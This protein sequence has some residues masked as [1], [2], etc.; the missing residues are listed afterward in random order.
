[1]KHPFHSP[2]LIEALLLLASAPLTQAQTFKVIH[3]FTGGVDGSLPYA[4]LTMDRAG[5]LYGTTSSGG[6]ADHGSVFRLKPSNG[7][8]VLNT[9]YSFDPLHKEDGASPES[10]VVFGPDGSLYGTTTYGG[11]SNCTN[12]CGTVYSLRPPQKVCKSAQCSWTE[13]ILYEF[14]GGNDGGYP[15]LGD[16]IFDSLRN[17]YGTTG[18]YGASD[19]GV[20]YELS[21]SGSGWTQSVLLTFDRANGSYPQSGLLFDQAGNLYGTAS[22]G[23]QYTYGMA[24][25][26][27]PS[28][29]GWQQNVLHAFQGNGDGIDPQGALISDSA[30][31]LYGTTAVGGAQDLGTVFELSPSGSGWSY[32]I[33]YNFT[34]QGAP[35]DTLAM[36]A[37][38]SLYGTTY[39][40]ASGEYGSVFRLSH[41]SGGW[42]Y[43][44]LYTFKGGHDGA[45][46]WG[47]VALDAAGNLYGTTPQGGAYGAGAV[48]EITP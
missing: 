15:A 45:H 34:D 43:T 11:V 20:V 4:G 1:M 47:S 16:L 19:V 42:T 32:A 12:G 6:T 36:D 21:P 30:G 17:I 14:T 33:L 23:G 25:R 8:W 39:G 38:G 18:R 27:T 2:A 24:L 48:W 22:Y 44:N 13:T 3:D 31:S 26:L 29:L 7:T 9:L 35:Q 5:N 10:R 28:A 40:N 46:P 41:S 37:A